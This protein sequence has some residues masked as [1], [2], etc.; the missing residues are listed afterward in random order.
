MQIS[1]VPAF[2]SRRTWREKRLMAMSEAELE[3]YFDELTALVLCD[4]AEN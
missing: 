2:E 1:A 3:R 4:G